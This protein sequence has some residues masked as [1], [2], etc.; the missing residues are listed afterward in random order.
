MNGSMTEGLLLIC[1]ACV[2]KLVFHPKENR[3]RLLCRL[4]LAMGSLSVMLQEDGAF[5]MITQ[6][7]LGM[8]M[9]MVTAAAL[10]GEMKAR[11]RMQMLHKRNVLYRRREAAQQLMDERHEERAA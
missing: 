3:N 4:L 7:L 10:N 2:L 9:V 5:L 6:G 8:I 11:R 1:A